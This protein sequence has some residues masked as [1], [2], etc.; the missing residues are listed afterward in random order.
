MASASSPSDSTEGT[1]VPCDACDQLEEGLINVEACQHSVCKRCIQEAASKSKVREVSCP[2]VQRGE[3]LCGG[4]LTDDDI[5]KSMDRKTFKEWK[6]KAN[7]RPSVCYNDKC[8]KPFLRKRFTRQVSC[9]DCREPNCAECMVI[10]RG[11][12]CA[13]YIQKYVDDMDRGRL[14]DPEEKEKRYRELV[15][16]Y[17]QECVLTTEEFECPRC[18]VEVEAGTGIILRN[19]LHS[20]CKECVANA[21]KESASTKVLC[22]YERDNVKCTMKMLDLDVQACM[23]KDDY[24]THCLKP[25]KPQLLPLPQLPQLP[26]LLPLDE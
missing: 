15:D 13:E 17:K 24:A 21:A 3:T 23:M 22:P 25:L 14:E 11:M 5:K 9:P 2:V 18:L 12:T 10:H 16:A 19:C 1:K 7:W 20:I 26:Q 8:K 6:D 4:S